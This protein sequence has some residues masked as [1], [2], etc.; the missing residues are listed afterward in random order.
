MSNKR[1]YKMSSTRRMRK[2]MWN[3]ECGMWNVEC[4]MWNVDKEK[5]EDNYISTSESK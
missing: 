4:G 5:R 1:K 3:M 2:W